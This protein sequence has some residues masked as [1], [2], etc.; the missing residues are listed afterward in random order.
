MFSRIL[1]LRGTQADN[2]G[3]HILCSFH[4]DLAHQDLD[5]SLKKEHHLTMFKP[6]LFGPRVLLLFLDPC[7]FK[8]RVHL[9]ITEYILGNAELAIEE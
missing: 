3:T 8:I 6:R 9:Y 5:K 4:R 1:V 7:T 2:S